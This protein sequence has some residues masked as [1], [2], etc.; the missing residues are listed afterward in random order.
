MRRKAFCIAIF[1]LMTFLWSLNSLGIDH[2]H[3]GSKNNPLD[4]L[5]VTWR[6]NYSHCNIRWGYTPS[7]EM[8]ISDKIEGRMEFGSDND[9]L[10]DYTFPPLKPSATLHFSFQECTGPYDKIQYTGEWSK[11]YTFKTSVS[12]DSQRFTFIAGGDSRGDTVEVKD[13]GEMAKV[14]AK[15]GADFYLYMGDLSLQGGSKKMW[16]NWYKEGAPF[17]A[18]HLVYHSLGNHETYGDPGSINYLD[19]FVLPENGNFTERHYSFQ[20]GN[21]VFIMLDT[22]LPQ[23]NETGR[24]KLA[25]Q[26]KWLKKE[27]RKYRGD[28]AANYK[29]WVIISFHSPFFTIDK[30]MGAMTG[31]NKKNP[32]YDFLGA[33]W[34]DV[35]DKYGVDV[36]INGHSHC[37]MRSVPLLLVGNGKDGGDLTFNNDG[38]PDKPARKVDYGNKPGQGRLQVVTGG[39]GAP[40]QKGKN[41]FYKDQ[42]YVDNYKSEFHYCIFTIDGKTLTMKVIDIKGNEIDSRTITH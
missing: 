37:Y 14:L 2:I 25:R 34:K 41:L 39:Y 23:T 7:Y 4:G 26:T 9:F 42:W 28:E 32:G 12:V 33:W 40:L 16:E 30:H 36:I 5:T 15:T 1:A 3:F 18:D 13:W 8:G 35:F 11:D 17:L 10:Y 6:G 31:N 21:A 29:E 22:E 38:L 20:F 19:Q 24:E 27:I